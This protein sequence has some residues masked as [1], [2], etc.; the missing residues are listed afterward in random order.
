MI[1]LAANT[2]VDSMRLP[3]LRRRR[4]IGE[5]PQSV[6]GGGTG[7]RRKHAGTGPIRPNHNRRSVVRRHQRGAVRQHFGSLG[8][9]GRAQRSAT[10]AG[11]RPFDREHRW[12]VDTQYL[13]PAAVEPADHTQRIDEL[14]ADQSERLLTPQLSCEESGDA[15]RTTIGREIAAPHGLAVGD[16]RRHRLGHRDAGCSIGCVDANGRSYAAGQRN[17]QAGVRPG[18]ANRDGDDRTTGR[19]AVTQRH[20]DRRLIGCRQSR[21]GCIADPLDAHGDHQ[22]VRKMTPYPPS[23]YDQVIA[24]SRLHT[25]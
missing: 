6:E 17:P 22:V 18:R 20:L 4:R 7:G 15:A 5:D 8:G 19:L 16:D 9:Q 12:A 25:R 1:R 10:Q 23:G 14:D 24:P 11:D 2:G 13:A 3:R 21:G